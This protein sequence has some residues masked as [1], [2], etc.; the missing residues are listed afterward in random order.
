MCSSDL[1][2]GYFICR[3][4]GTATR[5]GQ[6]WMY[7]DAGVFGGVIETTEGL[8]YNL[9]TERDGEPV[10]S[11][12]PV[13]E[14]DAVAKLRLLLVEPKA[15]GLGIGKRLVELGAEPRGSTPEEFAATIRT[16]MTIAAGVATTDAM[17]MC[18]SASGTAS[19]GGSSEY[20]Y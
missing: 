2:A 14:S 17:R 10:G 6:R 11:V 9:Y 16:E 13:R 8:R 12:F 1:D 4:V 18:A 19:A 5:N 20:N 7:W 3:V 15:R